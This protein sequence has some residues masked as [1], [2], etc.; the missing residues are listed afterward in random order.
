MLLSNVVLLVH[1]PLERRKYVLPVNEI[2]SRPSL[3]V[4][5]L[6]IGNAILVR[7][8]LAVVRWDGKVL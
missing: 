2:V 8:R 7:Q 4:E 5:Q 1:V 6:V 3:D